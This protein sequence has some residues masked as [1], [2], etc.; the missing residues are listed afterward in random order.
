MDRR[1]LRHVSFM[2]SNCSRQLTFPVRNNPANKNLRQII[3][4]SE[5]QISEDLSRHDK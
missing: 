1:R 3:E 5:A 2:R 4:W